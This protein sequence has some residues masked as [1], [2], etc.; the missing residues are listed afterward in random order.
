MSA[1]SVCQ[2]APTAYVSVRSQSKGK[3]KEMKRYRTYFLVKRDNYNK[4]FPDY[5][6]LAKD[7]EPPAV[8]L[9]VTTRSE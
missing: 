1:L 9:P 8:K 5:D 2:C 6:A 7:D 4:P 3:R